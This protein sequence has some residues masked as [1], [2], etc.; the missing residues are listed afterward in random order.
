[1]PVNVPNVQVHIPNPKGTSLTLYVPQYEVPLIKA[2][3]KSKLS[4]PVANPI[5]SK[6]LPHKNSD[7]ARCPVTGRDRFCGMRHTRALSLHDEKRRL[8]AKYATNPQTEQP[9]F[10]AVYPVN[11][12][13][14]TAARMYPSLFQGEDFGVEVAEDDLF[15]E[16]EGPEE[17]EAPEE[18]EE[19]DAP[20][21]PEEPDAP[22]GPE[23]P[24]APEGGNREQILEE[25]CALK[26][27]DDRLAEK[28]L[29]AGFDSVD[30]VAQ[31]DP[32]DL[33]SMVHGIG[34]KRST[35]IVDHAVVLATEAG[36]LTD[37]EE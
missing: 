2:M 32:D 8:A 5:T 37:P 13:E 34:A 22:E 25:L 29:A 7:V 31:T 36:G 14:S 17:P 24:D 21:G 4:D 19:P 16:P 20:E 33:A 12:F 3:W 11:M 9:I 6:H 27:V 30:E 10:D 1:M 23:E 15:A 18:P 35:E 26:H 28:M